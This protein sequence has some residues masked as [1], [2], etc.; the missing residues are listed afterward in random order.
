MS[1]LRPVIKMGKSKSYN[2]PAQSGGLVPFVKLHGLGNDFVLFD[3]REGSALAPV[4][5]PQLKAAHFRQIADRKRSVGFDQLLVLSSSS[6]VHAQLEIFNADGSVAEMCGNGLRAAALYLWSEGNDSGIFHDLILMIDTKA[7]DRQ[8]RLL[9]PLEPKINLD[10]KPDG[11]W[12]ETEMGRP[13]W[14]RTPASLARG[15]AL[16]HRTAKAKPVVGQQLVPILVNVGNPHAVFFLE[17]LPDSERLTV[18]GSQVENHRAFPRRTNV[19]FARV[20]NAHQVEAKVWE[21]GVGIT[22]ACGTG[23]VAVAVAAIRA[24]L[25]QSP[26]EVGFPG[27][28][29]E[30][31]WD[32]HGSAF[33]RGHACE[34]FRGQLPIY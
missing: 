26:V 23:G 30:V 4:P 9:G 27:G 29:V 28:T 31:V 21:R 5:L 6:R 1:R 20:I 2:A 15:V 3:F 24:G 12:I 16:K 22:E 34:S 13:H 32:G 7:G 33:L 18:W 8:A 19:E 25:C 11:A 10:E 17:K 14:P